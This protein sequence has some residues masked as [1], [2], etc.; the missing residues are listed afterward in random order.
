MLR[1]YI[2]NY[3]EKDKSRSN[4]SNLLKLLISDKPKF[5][6]INNFIYF[7][8]TFRQKFYHYLNEI[9]HKPTCFVCGADVLWVEALSSYRET[10]SS[11]CSGS[12][13]KYR[14]TSKVVSHPSL[15]TKE[16]YYN[17]FSS[18]KMKVMESSISNYY[19]ELLP[20]VQEISFVDDFNQ[21]VY[22]YLKGLKA[23]PVCKICSAEVQFETFSKGFHDYC[24]TK[25]SSNSEIKK[26]AIKSTVRSKYGVDNVGEATRQKALET[27][28]D[29][30][31]EHISKTEQ[32]K[33]KQIAFSLKKYNT[34]YYFQTEQFKKKAE[35]YYL[36][37]FGVKTQ[38]NIPE[39][40]QKCLQT[41][42]DKGL[43][44]KWSDEELKNYERYR[45]KVTYLSEKT[46][47]KN[48]DDINPDRLQR[49]HLTFHLDHIYPVILGFINGIDAELI[50]DARNLQILTHDENRNKSSKT[51]MT[52]EDF[53]NLI[54]K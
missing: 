45:Q 53:Y 38:M 21:K 20:H 26:E 28:I 39:V 5:D 43:I 13:A 52:L 30:Y 24:S 14:R 17:Y 34:R 46:Y 48:I 12:L 3:L 54:S 18:N 37:N 44:Y 1:E 40:V 29:K 7:E 2:K 27:M 31:G 32:F 35:E 41:K 9:K 47:L 36:T 19:P 6:E 50:A 51:E 23:K 11:K 42:K 8:S 16:D 10:C 33:E 49:G 25:C 15:S 22:C 4:K